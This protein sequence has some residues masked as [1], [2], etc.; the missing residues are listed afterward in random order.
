MMQSP[1]FEPEPSALPAIEPPSAWSH[2]V[3]EEPMMA[4][5][6]VGLIGVVV[7]LIFRSR[8][9][10]QRGLIGLGVAGL[11]VGGLWMTS[12]MVQ[13]DRELVSDRA[14]A[15]VVA[16]AVGD[17]M[18]MSGL[19]G[20]G[21]VVQSRFASAKGR[22]RVI[23]LAAARVPGLVESVS[24]SEIQADFPGPRV[25]RTMVKV[26][27]DGSYVPSSSWWMIHW[28]WG[29]WGERG[30]ESDDGWVAVYI[31]PLWIQGVSHPGG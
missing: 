30:D 2:A 9:Q 15:L 24:V 18:G 29:E 22:D 4:M 26:R 1:L 3:F 23:A 6:V 12:T 25:G 14:R 27:V 28:E 20:D 10:L 19:M 5:I 8:G 21:V 13:T 7:V 17:R 31:E 16:V 11:A